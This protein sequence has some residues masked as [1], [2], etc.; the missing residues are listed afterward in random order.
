MIYE[1]SATLSVYAPMIKIATI[2]EIIG[3]R[4]S[5]NFNNSYLKP[6]L[7]LRSESEVQILAVATQKLSWWMREIFLSSKSCEA[8]QK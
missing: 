1:V 6:L 7:V 3:P 4:S 5:I 2:L 8:S